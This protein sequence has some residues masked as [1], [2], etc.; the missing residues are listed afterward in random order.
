MHTVDDIIKA[1]KFLIEKGFGNNSG[2]KFYKVAELMAEW[3]VKNC[4]MPVVSNSVCST[5]IH[6]MMKSGIYKECPIVAKSLKKLSKILEIIKTWLIPRVST[7]NG[8][9]YEMSQMSRKFDSLKFWTPDLIEWIGKENDPVKLAVASCLVNSHDWPEW[10]PGRPENYNKK[11]ESPELY[12]IVE[13]YKM[14]KSKSENIAPKLYNY[15][16]LTNY[17]RSYVC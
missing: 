3:S 4:S 11:A 5:T 8:N 1:K 9:D 16:W 2:I 7:R 6:R 13:L 15:I 12:Y 10:L 17:Y 14:L